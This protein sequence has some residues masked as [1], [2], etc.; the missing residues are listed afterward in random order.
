QECRRDAERVSDLR[1]AEHRG[2]DDAAKAVPHEVDAHSIAAGRTDCG[3]EAMPADL[4]ADPGTLFHGP[5]GELAQRRG[6]TVYHVVEPA[7]AQTT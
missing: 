2:D 6:E 3:D 4:A 7:K 5:E 1:T